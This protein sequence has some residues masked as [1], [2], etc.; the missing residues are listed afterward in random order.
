MDKI[1]LQR[2]RQPSPHQ[3]T[4]KTQ[5]GC[6]T[7]ILKRSISGTALFRMLQT[8]QTQ[9]PALLRRQCESDTIAK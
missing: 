5:Q 4:A 7:G 9:T 6:G 8:C 3:P 2:L 1:E